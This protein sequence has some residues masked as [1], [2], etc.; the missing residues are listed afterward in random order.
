M[1]F[2][3]ALVRPLLPITEVPYRQRSSYFRLEVDCFQFKSKPVRFS[4]RT[5][6]GAFPDDSVA[7]KIPVGS[8]NY[9]IQLFGSS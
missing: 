9:T 4:T 3:E 6:Y 7:L 1:R 2:V 8:L 5:D